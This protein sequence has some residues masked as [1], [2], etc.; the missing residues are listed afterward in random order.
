MKTRAPWRL[1][2]RTKPSI[3]AAAVE[4]MIGTAEKSIT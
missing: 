1:A 3:V 2:L 4:S